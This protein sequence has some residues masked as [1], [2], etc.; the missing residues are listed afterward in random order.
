MHIILKAKKRSP[1]DD[2]S[3]KSP[4][5]DWLPSLGQEDASLTLKNLGTRHQ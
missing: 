2:L 3:I 5:S 1:S 4:H